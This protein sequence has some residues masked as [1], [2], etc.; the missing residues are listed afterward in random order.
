MNIT[1]PYC[2]KKLSR[3]VTHNCQLIF[4]SSIEKLLLNERK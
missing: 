2:E 4:Q 1:H 3:L